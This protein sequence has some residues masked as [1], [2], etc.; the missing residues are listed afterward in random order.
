MENQQ[1]TQQKRE[2]N[3]TQNINFVHWNAAECRVSDVC[4]TW[5]FGAAFAFSSARFDIN[6][7]TIPLDT[8]TSLTNYYCIWSTL[9]GRWFGWSLS[10]SFS[11]PLLHNIGCAKYGNSYSTR[12]SYW[13]RKCGSSRKCLYRV[14]NAICRPYDRCIGET[15]SQVEQCRAHSIIFED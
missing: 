9:A 1:Q 13:I 5:I 7:E 10:N 8:E 2:A 15:F 6:C 11:I 4:I 3:A 12:S 14:N